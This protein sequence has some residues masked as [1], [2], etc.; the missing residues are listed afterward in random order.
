MGTYVRKLPRRLGQR[1]SGLYD[2]FWKRVGGNACVETLQ[3]NQCLSLA[4]SAGFQWF[5]FLRGI[6]KFLH[7]DMDSG[8]GM[9]R[10]F[11]TKLKRNTDGFLLHRRDCG[12]VEVN[13][14]QVS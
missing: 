9:L 5:V 11:L 8:P 1:M 12:G 2:S 10:R 7:S 3:V 6:D 13:G 4:K 14:I